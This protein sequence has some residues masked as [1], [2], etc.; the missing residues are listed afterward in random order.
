MPERLD[1]RR[2]ERGGGPLVLSIIP[3][4]AEFTTINSLHPIAR[5]NFRRE[6]GSRIATPMASADRQDRRDRPTTTSASKVS[7]ELNQE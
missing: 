7:R 4:S 5:F 6:E 1:L 3:V 2:A